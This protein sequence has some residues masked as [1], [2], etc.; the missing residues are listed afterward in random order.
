MKILLINSSPR[1]TGCTA[2]A[3][4]YIE[5]ALVGEGLL[6]EHVWLG[7]EATLSCLGCGR[8]HSTGECFYPDVTN[9]VA[10][11]AREADGFVFATPVHYAGASGTLKSVM[12]RLFYSAKDAFRLK[13]AFGV[14]V[15]RRGGNVAALSEI[16]KF[17]T[18]SEMPVVSGNYWCILHGTSPS[19]V[20]RDREGIQTV[21]VA[22]RNLAYFV[23]CKS[24]AQDAG[25]F[26]PPAVEKIRTNYIL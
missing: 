9:S 2:R 15:G 3:L 21:E 23:K 10:K 7:R 8:C 19:E 14:A 13:P 26:P 4:S 5:S 25:I 6:A 11:R 24:A 20:D 1:P 18:F 16:E 12:G 17:F 22:A